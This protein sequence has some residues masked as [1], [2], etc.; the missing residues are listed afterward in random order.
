MNPITVEDVAGLVM[1]LAQ[2]FGQAGT[3]EDPDA[4]AALV[5][6]W[7]RA[8]RGAQ[9]VDVAAAMQNCLT[10]V[11]RM[12]SVAQFRGMVNQA[13]DLRHRA[14]GPHR[15]AVCPLC[16]G[17]RGFQ[18]L[19]EDDSGRWFVQPCPNGC[20]A[21]TAREATRRGRPVRRDPHD[22]A[23]AARFAAGLALLRESLEDPE[24]AAS[25][26]QPRRYTP[27]PA[28]LALAA[29]EEEF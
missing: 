13:A 5:D 29:A 21:I 16:E 9:D 17:N 3:L 27:P 4:A 22:P 12:P 26:I 2:N 24:G 25:L 8:L 15:D 23:A 6:T 20:R 28:Q 1:R 11:T 14:P 19:G 7:F 10:T 18:D